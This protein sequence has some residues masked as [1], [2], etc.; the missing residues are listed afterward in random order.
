M[1]VDSKLLQECIKKDRSAQYELY[2]LSYGFMM[3]ICIRYANDKE[4]AASFMNEGFLKV[5]TR[6]ESYRSTVPFELWVRRILINT[7]IDQY[8]RNKKR[9][10]MIEYKDMAH[11]GMA[12]DT[13]LNHAVSKMDIEQLHQFIEQLPEMSRR[14]FNLY[15]IDGY[16][17]PEIAAL[18]HISE[19]TSK[20][21]LSTSRQKLQQMILNDGTA[22]KRKIA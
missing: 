9:K 1:I 7:I 15:V 22:S 20:W 11:H 6:L 12:A 14:V 13:V 2:R 19:G 5:L 3:G 17:H 4:E 21:H 18:L 10:E 8:R 16:T